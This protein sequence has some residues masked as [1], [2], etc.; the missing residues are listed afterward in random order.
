[1]LNVKAALEKS[2]IKQA[3][4]AR[5]CRVSPATIAQA[6]NHNLWPKRTEDELKGQIIGFLTTHK[7]AVNDPFSAVKEVGEVD[8]VCSN[9]PDPDQSNNNESNDQSQ[10]DSDMLL[11]KQ[12][13]TPEAKR[14]F[15]VMRNP[16]GDIE[17]AEEMWVSP[18]IR[19][20]RESMLQTAKHGGFLAV[21]GESGAGKTS[22]M[23]DLEARIEQEKLPIIIIKPYVLAAED[24]DKKGKTLKSTHIAEALLST[25][26][27]LEK[28][29]MS[30]EARFRQ[31]HR[32]LQGS[33]ASGYRHCLVIEEAHSLP[34]P[35][36]KH[37][38]RILEL[39]QGFTKLVSV[40]LI[41]QPELLEKLSERNPEVREVVQRCEVATLYPIAT[42]KLREYLDFRLGRFGKRSSDLFDD[43]GIDAITSRLVSRS[44]ASQLYPLA[45][46]NFVV[47]A[48]NMAARLGMDA[49]DAD[50]VKEV[51]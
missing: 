11:R 47:S 12:T 42:D 4:L 44:G 9:T 28:I 48:M 32:A 15:G 2:A 25:V 34:I 13:L 35:T 50:I 21:V 30:P 5:H 26:A 46:G 20:V 10:E 31:L 27:P 29:K 33:H 38:K 39:Q 45:V 16:F 23:L 49:I 22:V 8:P 18:D 19:Y 1:M 41:G 24:S 17:S 3:E 40:I 14:Q 36:L 6:L 37:L 51:V 7:I 43:T